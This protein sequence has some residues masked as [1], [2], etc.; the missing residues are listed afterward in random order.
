MVNEVLVPN[1]IWVLKFQFCSRAVCRSGWTCSTLN[2]GGVGAEP[3]MGTPVAAQTNEPQSALL[4][5][6]AGL[7]VGDANSCCTP[8]TPCAGCVKAP[9]RAPAPKIPVT[10]GAWIV[11]KFG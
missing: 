10:C 5:N 9:P 4:K 6:S 1:A 7:S 8:K 11:P 2:V 3:K